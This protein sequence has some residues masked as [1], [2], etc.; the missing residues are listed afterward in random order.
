M[1]V[2]KFPTAQRAFLNNEIYLKPYFIGVL[3]KIIGM[4][5]RILYIF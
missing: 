5:Y 1:A 3:L 4:Y 2:P